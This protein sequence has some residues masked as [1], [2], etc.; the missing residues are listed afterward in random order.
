MMACKKIDVDFSYSPDQPKAGEKVTFTNLSTG[1]EEWAWTFGDGGTSTLKSPTYTYK[2][3]GTYTVTLKV[4]GKSSRTKVHEITVYDTIPT[5][6]AS[7]SA[8]AI[9]RDYSFQA[10]VYNPYNYE[11]KYLWYQPGDEA[12]Y[13]TVT[14]TTT[15]AATLHLY[16]TRPMTEAR[17]GLLVVLNGDTTR[18]E[19]SFLVANRE[20]NSVLFRNAQGDYRQRIFGQ[21]AEDVRQ[22]ASAK[23]LL[24]AEQ[25]T[26][27]L[28][29]GKWF[30]MSELKPIFPELQGF[31][32]AGRKIYYRAEG[33]GLWVAS[34]DGA[35]PVQIETEECT[36]MTIDL[37]DNRIYWAVANEVRY[38]PLVG[39]DNNRFVTVPQTINTL[40]GVTRI[41]V[42]GE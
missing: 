23:A 41:P 12:P 2:N 25:D 42:D 7:D 15:R 4:D 6:S 40:G 17:L 11:V 14:D 1:G 31:K 32:I 37:V 27:Q 16:F 3:P 39:S 29:N 22:D 10:L 28:Y 13:Y 20:T 18:I 24:D 9:Y 21:R 34:I 30:K 5:Y 26:A 35:N 38:M 36:A 19:K 8:F 33:E